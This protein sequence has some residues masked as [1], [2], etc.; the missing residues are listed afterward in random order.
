TLGGLDFKCEYDAVSSTY[1]IQARNSPG[2]LVISTTGYSAL[3]T[4]GSSGTV[5]VRNSFRGL[6][7]SWTAI[8]DIGIT[9]SYQSLNI[10]LYDPLGAGGTKTEFKMWRIYAARS[11]WSVVTLRVEYFASPVE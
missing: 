9:G 8:T 1:L 4:S 5:T 2:K 11:G 3:K 6:T 7:D 10:E